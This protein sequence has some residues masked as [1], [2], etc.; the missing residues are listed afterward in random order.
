MLNSAQQAAWQAWYPQRSDEWWAT[1]QANKFVF[2]T[3]TPTGATAVTFAEDGG[4]TEQDAELPACGPAAQADEGL[5]HPF[6]Y[7]MSQA[8]YEEISAEV[9]WS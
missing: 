9:P 1:D 8:A 2:A 4:T 7:T 6:G 3:P 5:D